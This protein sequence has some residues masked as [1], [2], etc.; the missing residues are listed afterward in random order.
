MFSCVAL[1]RI[2]RREHRSTARSVTVKMW[3]G[4]VGSP[5]K[6]RNKGAYWL[7][8]RSRDVDQP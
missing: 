1:L 6:G 4:E 8:K 3:Q 5:S 2:S 7:S